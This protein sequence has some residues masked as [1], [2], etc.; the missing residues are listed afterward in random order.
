MNISENVTIYSETIVPSA[1][2]FASL[3]VAGNIF[4]HFPLGIHR[5]GIAREMSLCSLVLI[6]KEEN[7]LHCFRC[8]IPALFSI[9]STKSTKGL[10]F[11][12]AE[13][14]LKSR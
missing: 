12:K 1:T 14:N 13:D 5:L 3:L 4:G 2:L 9:V 8:D 11:A 7:L 10:R 6:I